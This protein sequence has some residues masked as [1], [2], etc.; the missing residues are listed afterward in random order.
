MSTKLSSAPARRLAD[1]RTPATV[2]LLAAAI[3]VMPGASAPQL[4]ARAAGA[5]SPSATPTSAGARSAPSQAVL[6]RQPE[7]RRSGTRIVVDW[8]DLTPV[9]GERTAIAG[10]VPVPRNGGPRWVYL[11]EWNFEDG[12]WAYRKDT[13]SGAGGRFRLAVTLDR[14][15]EPRRF[16][17]SVGKGP[18]VPPLASK[19]ATFT[20]VWQPAGPVTR[21]YPGMTV[22]WPG[23]KVLVG[24]AQVVRGTVTARLA[25]PSVALQREVGGRWTEIARTTATGAGDFALRLPTAYLGTGSYRL[26][27]TDGAGGAVETPAERLSI[28]PDYTPAGRAANYS[29]VS[30]SPVG[31]WDPCAP[32]GY[33]V[34]LAK[35]PSGALPDVRSALAEVAEATGLRFEYR[36]TTSVVPFAAGDTFDPAVADLVIA[37]ADPAQMRGLFPTGTLGVGGPE[38]RPTLAVDP[39]GTPVREIYQGGVTINTAFNKALKPGSGEGLTRVAALMHEIGH[40]VG[41]MHV[42]GDPAQLMS[43]SVGYGLDRWGAG[44]LAGLETVGAAGGCLTPGA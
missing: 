9:Q 28:I 41:L 35:A 2:A 43:P 3:I 12:V 44:D 39:S 42:D 14:V 11:E 17:I 32:I 24:S 15:N 22:V 40:A 7:T 26:S 1:A 4:A 13:R 6:E 29:L 20:A 34:N 21:T 25:K 23:A 19:A 31:R 5:V 37:W 27:I 36:G 33:R 10:S 38:F 8:G 18:G 30:A 16:R